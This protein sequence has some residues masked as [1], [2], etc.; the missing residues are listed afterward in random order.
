MDSRLA[1]VAHPASYTPK[2]PDSLTVLSNGVEHGKNLNDGAELD[3]G[4]D[5]L[6]LSLF[7]V[8]PVMV[9]LKRSNVPQH[10]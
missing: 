4:M 9:R 6:A 2:T 8:A 7:R 10:L 3:K 1:A 5:N